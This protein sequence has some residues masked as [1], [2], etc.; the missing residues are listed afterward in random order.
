MTL[1]LPILNLKRLGKSRDPSG[2]GEF[3]PC[4][5]VFWKFNYLEVMN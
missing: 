3:V 5:L 4:P 1:L 2:M